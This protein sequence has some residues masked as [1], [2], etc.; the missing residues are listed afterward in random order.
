MRLGYAQISKEETS[1]DQLNALENAGCDKIFA[2]H[3][4]G[5]RGERRGLSKALS[6]LEKGDC[7]VI[8][9][10]DRLGKSTKQLLD[11]VGQLDQRGI[12]FKS[13]SD[14]IDTSQ[15][16]GK[17]M[18]KA[19]QALASFEKK[20]IVER[21]KIGVATARSKGK[22]VGRP[23]HVSEEGAQAILE[24]RQ[25][26]PEAIQALCER[27]KISKRSYYRYIERLLK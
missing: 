25:A 20:M 15:P 13:I 12:H 9:K 27:L 26:G 3:I 4:S 1:Q 8:W 18:M 2:D 17:P 10:F 22:I 14:Q 16:S 24:A 21:A 7:L 11:V 23:R 5:R 19:F 6:R